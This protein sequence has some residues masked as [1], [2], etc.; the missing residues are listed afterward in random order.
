MNRRGCIH[1]S[2]VLIKNLFEFQQI[3]EGLECI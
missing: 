2:D 1:R 3:S